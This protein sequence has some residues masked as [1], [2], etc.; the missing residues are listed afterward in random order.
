MGVASATGYVPRA[1]PRPV[2][3]G[4]FHFWRLPLDLLLWRLGSVGAVAGLAPRARRAVKRE[5]VALNI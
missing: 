3:A 5:V 4:R 2:A 1:T